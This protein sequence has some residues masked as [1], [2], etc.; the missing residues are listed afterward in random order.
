MR[1]NGQRHR[2]RW[3]TPATPAAT[4]DPSL[5]PAARWEVV[6]ESQEAC[7]YD[8]LAAGDAGLL[9]G[10]TGV[11][12]VDHRALAWPGLHLRP[13]HGKGRWSHSAPS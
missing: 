7:S 9:A 10:R 3:W 8:L 6:L 13:R 4:E 11:A 12:W 1:R 5:E 2:P